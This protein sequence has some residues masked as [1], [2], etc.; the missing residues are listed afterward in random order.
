VSE[1]KKYLKKGNK[2]KRGKNNFLSQK[3]FTKRFKEKKIS[4]EY[5][6]GLEDTRKSKLKKKII[7]YQI[8]RKNSNIVIS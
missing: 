1:K 4:K 3:A 7:L 5:R 6:Q 8:Y 2:C